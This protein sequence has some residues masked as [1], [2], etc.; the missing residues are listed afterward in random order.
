MAIRI[1][2]A[3]V[4]AIRIGATPVTQVR[5]GS[6]IVWSAGAAVRDDFVRPNAPN[7]GPQWT[8][9]V[10]TNA[11]YLAGVQDNYCRIAI[12]DM[13][14]WDV[15]AM[16]ESKMRYNA[17]L[18][19][20]GDGYVE[21]RPATRGDGSGFA[22]FP[23]QVFRRAANTGAAAGVGIDMRSS[24]L[25][26]V[27]RIASVDALVPCGSYEPGDVLRLIESGTAYSM[28]RNGEF[29]GE[30]DDAGATVSKGPDFCSM[31]LSVCGYKEFFGPRRLSPGVD[32]VECG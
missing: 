22:Q 29:V 1:G 11:L 13:W 23:T 10:H 7:L 27:R 17:A 30:W 9:E 8:D 21:T 12:P 6:A 2:G 3:P 24:N 26:I 14:P 32:Y 4:T 18:H 15:L 19:P 16:V 31:M 5:L 25:S 28:Y 20:D